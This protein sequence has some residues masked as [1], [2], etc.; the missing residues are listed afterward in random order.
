MKTP[1][2]SPGLH[3]VAMKVRLTDAAVIKTSGRT[4]RRIFLKGPYTAWK[5]EKPWRSRDH[6]CRYSNRRLEGLRDEND[7]PPSI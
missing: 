4:S 5:S 6:R 1:I 3:D 2:Y 7:H